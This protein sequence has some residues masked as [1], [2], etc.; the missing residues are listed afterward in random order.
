[1]AITKFD[2]ENEFH[3]DELIIFYHDEFAKAVKQ[4]GYLKSPPSLLDL[5]VE[6]LRHGE[7]A[8]V[9]NIVFIPFLFMDPDAVNAEDY[10]AADKRDESLKLKIKLMQQPS[11]EKLLKR[12]LKSWVA[13]GYL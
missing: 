5:N 6:L 3:N 10:I 11:C 4:F 9:Q 8:M 12:A 7:F 13:K 2:E 1:M